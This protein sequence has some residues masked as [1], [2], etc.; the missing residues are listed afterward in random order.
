TA[1]NGTNDWG[2]QQH[3]NRELI[4]RGGNL[5]WP[6]KQTNNWN[7]YNATNNIRLLDPKLG[8][9]RDN[10]SGLL[11][12]ALLSGSPAINSG[13]KNG[14]PSVDQRGAVRDSA[15]DS[16]AVEFGVEVPDTGGEPIPVP[17]DDAP[18]ENPTDTPVID[19]GL[20][21]RLVGTNGRD[22]LIGTSAADKILGRGGR[23]VLKGK[24]G[25]DVL[26]GGGA[27]DRL[28]GM[29]GNDKLIGQAGNDVLIGGRGKDVLKGG[30]GKDRYVFN[31]PKDGVDKIRGFEIQGDRLDLSPIFKGR[32]F[33]S[34]NPL[35]DYVEL[36]QRGS[37][38]VVSVDV[39]GDRQ[40][41]GFRNLAIL[42][43]TDANDLSGKNFK[44]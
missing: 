32:A 42:L 41:G 19:P 9:L 5:Q 39:N 30:R 3:T 25:K 34:R 22:R 14:S 10:G 7:D 16:G 37:R 17:I 2:I 27:N 8:A 21:D 36:N 33:Q 1:D 4:D 18:S 43:G 26:K 40:P 28:L 15:P 31:S 38:T 13:A 20:G 44:L 24:G 12:H 23:D 6:P 35:A 11:T 29:G